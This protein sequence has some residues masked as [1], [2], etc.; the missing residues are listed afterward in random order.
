M[1]VGSVYLKEKSGKV[2]K[3]VLKA[4]KNPKKILL[5]II[6]LPICSW[7]PDTLYLK[8]VYRLSIG[9]KLNLNNPKTFNEKLQWLKLYDRKPEYTVMVDKFAVRE[10]IADKIGEKYLIPL[11]GV[12]DS[13]DDIDFDS[14][15]D[16]FVL[17]CNHNSG[18]GMCICKDKSKLNIKQ[19]RKE[20]KKGLKQNY[21]KHGREWPYKNVPRKIIA[22]KYMTD[23]SGELNDYKIMCFNG[24]FKCAFTCTDR[25]SPEGIKVTF[26][27]KDWNVMPFERHYPKS[28]IPLP[29][30]EN[31]NKMIELS[32]ILSKEI[33]FARIDWYE[34]E[35]KLYFGE[36][37]FFP[38]SGFEEFSPEIWD[39]RLGNLIDLTKVR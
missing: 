28:K 23:N 13:P 38:G 12:W 4:I 32:E 21:Y 34:V 2:I 30:P 3:K 14:L 17:K 35:G 1:A 24:K 5:Y 8:I 27:D 11:I 18:F 39:T 31:F 16:K 33:A 7:L 26:Y 6:G 19:V 20:L 22:E 15:P 9:K 37:T 25:F 10:Y 29:Q 36:I